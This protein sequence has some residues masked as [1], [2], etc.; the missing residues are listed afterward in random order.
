MPGKPAA[1]GAL[2]TDIAAGALSRGEVLDIGDVFDPDFGVPMRRV[3][4]EHGVDDGRAWNPDIAR[5][6][7]KRRNSLYCSNAG[8]NCRVSRSSLRY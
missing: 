6:A 8:G 2:L 1:I 4:A 5:R 7:L 3:V